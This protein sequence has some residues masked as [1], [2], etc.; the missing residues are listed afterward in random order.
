[1]NLHCLFWGHRPS[2]FNMNAQSGKGQ[3][4]FTLHWGQGESHP[5]LVCRDCGALYCDPKEFVK[6]SLR[7]WLA[8][9]MKAS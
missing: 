5:V 1:M 7:I 3:S 2:G 6:D 8:Q 9:D 4:Q